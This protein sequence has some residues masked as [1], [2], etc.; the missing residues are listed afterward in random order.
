MAIFKSGASGAPNIS[1][2]GG[3]VAIFRSGAAGAAITSSMAATV[4]LIAAAGLVPGRSGMLPN[5]SDKS[6]T[7]I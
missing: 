4:G 3:A 7:G 1:S 6:S 5:I 2:A